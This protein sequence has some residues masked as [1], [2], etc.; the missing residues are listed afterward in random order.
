M[1]VLNS[2]YGQDSSAKHVSRRAFS[3]RDFPTD[4]QDN[5]TFRLPI[6]SSRMEVFGDGKTFAVGA[7]Y[8]TFHGGTIQSAGQAH[9]LQLRR[10]IVMHAIG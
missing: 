2:K 6:T 1:L 10:E 8:S 9:G 5:V 4:L 7:K 3:I